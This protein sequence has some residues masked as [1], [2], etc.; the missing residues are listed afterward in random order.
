MNLINL[1][2]EET[3]KDYTSTKPFSTAEHY[4]EEGLRIV[5][6]EGFA[7]SQTVLD[8]LSERKL[9]PYSMKSVQD[10]SDH[11]LYKDTFYST[12]VALIRSPAAETPPLLAEANRSGI[13][14]ALL[15][16]TDPL[17]PELEATLLKNVEKGIAVVIVK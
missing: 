17:T 6:F 13:H 5:E 11:L 14:V 7:P 3:T 4:V 1:F 12:V 8:S 16:I 9:I 15:Q 2:L 10:V